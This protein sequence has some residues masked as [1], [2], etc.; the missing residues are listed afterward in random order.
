MALVNLSEDPRVWAALAD[1][2]RDIVTADAER[3]I[4]R[5]HILSFL[6]SSGWTDTDIDAYIVGAVDG[7]EALAD[8]E[9]ERLRERKDPHGRGLSIRDN[10][11]NGNRSDALRAAR[12]DAVGAVAA[13]G[14]MAVFE[15]DTDTAEEF[16]SALIR[17]DAHYRG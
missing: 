11:I 16:A 7:A 17:A 15:R 14:A 10:W 3:T 13:Y 9:R 8:A 5:G 12:Y 4:E 6:R 1:A 2:V